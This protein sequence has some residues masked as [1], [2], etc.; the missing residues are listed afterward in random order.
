M[1][2]INLFHIPLIEET[3]STL[4][5]G[6]EHPD[7][8]GAGVNVKLHH[9]RGSAHSDI[10]KIKATSNIR[11][12]SEICGEGP[13]LCQRALLEGALVL[14]GI[15]F[16][17]HGDRAWGRQRRLQQERKTRY[18]SGDEHFGLSVEQGC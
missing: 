9:L 6:P 12:I 13:A 16:D 18:Q 10:D 15:S 4:F 2:D 17:L 8:G 1:V 3:T 5:R 11:V 14:V 7:I